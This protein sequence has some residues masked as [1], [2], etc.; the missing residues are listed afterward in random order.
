[1]LQI[2]SVRQISLLRN[3]RRLEIDAKQTDSYLWNH[4]D[5]PTN[6]VYLKL[7]AVELQQSKRLLQNLTDLTSLAIGRIWNDM[8]E[9][10]AFYD[11]NMGL[12]TCDQI[13]SQALL[14]LDLQQ[15][16]SKM[17]KLTDLDINFGGLPFLA[18]EFVGLTKLTSLKC[19]AYDIFPC[20]P[21]HIQTLTNLKRLILPELVDI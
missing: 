18:S 15:S 11:D 17:T 12:C 13:D 8:R 14:T 2:Q 20:F 10:Y 16:I 5:L 9:D 19:R 3:L 1:M 21:I 7:S 4:I 6:L